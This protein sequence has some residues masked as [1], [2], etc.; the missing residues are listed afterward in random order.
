MTSRR[1]LAACLA[2]LGYIALAIVFTYPLALQLTSH[3]P[4]EAGGDAKIYLW[5]YWWVGE[6][7][8]ERGVSPF[9]TDAIFHPIGI[10]LALHT[11]APAQGVVHA[12]LRPVVG[13]AGAVNLLILW[14]FVAS[15]LATFTLA[16]RL[17]ATASGAF[18]AGVAFAYCPYRLARLAGHYDLLGTEWIPLFV[19]L[20][21]AIA[22]S[23]RFPATASLGAGLVAAACGYTALSYLVFLAM[24]T[25]AFVAW[26]RRRL[27][28]IVPALALAAVTAG[29]LLYPLLSQAVRD[30][31]TWSYPPY[32]GAERYGADLLAFVVPPAGQ[33]WV[34]G[35][36]FGANA[37]EATV[38]P[39]L[40]LIVLAAF[41]LRHRFW[42][43]V[44]GVCFVLSLGASLHVA[45]T[46]TG[47]PLPFWLLSETPLLD[48]LR[49][50]SRFTVLLMLSLA[51]MMALSWR[52]RRGYATGLV[53]AALVV[54]YLSAPIPTFTDEPSAVQ[55]WLRDEPGSGTVIEIRGERTSAAT[56]LEAAS[57][58]GERGDRES[59]L[60]H[61]QRASALAPENAL[62]LDALAELLDRLERNADLADVLE[63]RA[64]LALDDPPT[65]A[66][67]LTELGELLEE[68]LFDPEAALD[69]YERARAADPGTPGID[70]A[71]SRLRAKLE[72]GSPSRRAEPVPEPLE[73]AEL[74]A[75]PEQPDDPEIALRSFEQEAS[76]CHDRARL[77]MLAG[78]I[79]RLHQQRGSADQALPVLE[80]WVA[81]APE[82][83]EAHRA[84]AR[85][86]ERA[87][88]KSEL[89]ATLEALDPLLDSAQQGA[90]RRQMA[91]LYHECG[92]IDDAIRAFE[93]AL[94]TDSSDLEALQG[95]VAVLRQSDRREDLVV[96]QWRL[97][98]RL[99]PSLRP[100]CLLELAELQEEIGDAPG[101]IE[102]LARLEHD[103]GEAEDSEQIAERLD[104]LLERTG[105]L[106]ELVER[107]ATRHDSHDPA[108]A[109]AVALELRRAELLES[110]RREEEAA[111]AYRHVLSHA[112]ES[113]Q[114]KA[115]LE[116]AL[117]SS[118]DADGLE[119]FLA[120]RVDDTADP[121]ERDR[122]ALERA[123]ILEELLG[124]VDEAVE[125][126]RRLAESGAAPEV[127]SDAS[128]RL[129]RVLE[130]AGEWEVLRQHLEDALGRGTPQEDEG[131]HERLARLSADRLGDEAAELSHFERVVEIN[132]GRADVWRVLAERYQ[133]ESRDADLH[134][135]LESELAAGVDPGRELTLHARLADL[136]SELLGDSD[137][138]TEHYERVFELNP[139][140]TAA[141]HFLMERYQ[142]AD[143]P[144]DVIRV[145]EARLASIEA[146]EAQVDGVATQR[147]SLR[148]Q[149]A[150]VRESRLDDLEGA[151]S[152]LEVALE[153][154][155]PEPSVVERLREPEER[156][157]VLRVIHE[158][159]SIDGLGLGGPARVE[160]LGAQR[161][162]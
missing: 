112:P 100:A 156:P 161:L 110:L 33:T 119:T 43:I 78:E 121:S 103:A 54:E 141:A 71:L 39:G 16:R 155:G 98:E 45:G 93:S 105:R 150:R 29:I 124:R 90:H 101:A 56:L 108:S 82:E 23:E 99:D 21:V 81:A 85:A 10:G 125:E 53:A 73:A 26:R 64:V 83:P 4:G 41:G 37:T 32:P 107:L 69:A 55:A 61:L 50:P 87:G 104:D 97:A 154:A 35:A 25:I 24:F 151:I 52:P 46:N 153:E 114:A 8:F 66:G 157:A 1:A 84:V 137:R 79:Q 143:R 118:I 162:A 115:G 44:A 76:V 47:V 13:D 132:P 18:L 148:V 49:A 158:I 140:H 68:R 38:Y 6:A 72:S 111:L 95:L 102:T 51:M 27:R 159:L 96:A 117:R 48:N 152:A 135:A 142:A 60:T 86:Y 109:E 146:G 34:P 40:V 59:A 89:L 5:S 80:R 128:R 145:L 2:L 31:R 149:I 120:Q 147:T 19:L 138:A 144:E 70:E 77:G 88:R 94:S 22:E 28:R 127:R 3:Y 12:V 57:L 134:R 113:P 20:L 131:L 92:R 116:R 30:L 139:A 36:S 122:S 62:V 123:V 75:P 7:L 130:S 133:H 42:A 65:H 136:A 17:G 14:T 63:R 67:V 91:S 58:L 160:Q 126:Y 74:P 11:L 15:A 9:E 129:Q 106:G